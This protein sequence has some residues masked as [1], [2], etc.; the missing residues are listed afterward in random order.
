[1]KT[2]GIEN[3]RGGSYSKITLKEDEIK[4]LKKEIATAEK[5]CFN[6]GKANH[7]ASE[8]QESIRGRYT[9]KYSR[10]FVECHKCG[11]AGHFASECYARVSSDEESDEYD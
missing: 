3:V 11:R 5:L 1:M 8:C 2:Y 4:F 10:K 9:P 7:I 6:C